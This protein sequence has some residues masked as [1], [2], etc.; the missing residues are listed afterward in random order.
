MATPPLILERVET[1]RRNLESYVSPDYKEAQLRREFL[2]P[3]F[4]ALGW[5]MQNKQGYA[6]AYK[7]VVH[8]DTLRISDLGTK[9]PD[10]SFRIGG[11]RKFFVEAKKPAVSIKD[12]PEPAQQLRRYS[13]SAKLPL[14]ILTDFQ[15]FAIYD[16]RIK[17]LKNDPP[18]KGRIFYCKFGEYPQ[19]WDEIAAIFSRDA[20]LK[21]SF[22]R[23]AVSVRGKRGTA[24]VDEDFLETLNGWRLRLAK[25]L[26]L[27]NGR[28]SQR[29]LNFA[30]QRILD[31][32][33]FLRI[34]E[35]RGI[36]NYGQLLA[37]T[38]SVQVEEAPD[39]ETEETPPPVDDLAVAEPTPVY[40]PRRMT[41]YPRLCE[42]FERADFR[43][44]SGLFHFH[45]EKGRDEAPDLLTLG[46]HIDDLVL[47]DII[48]GLYYPESPYVFSVIASEILGHVYEQFLGKVIRLTEG[49]RAV[50]E[51]KPEVR[52]AGGVYYTPTYIVDYI[53]RQAVG[54]LVADKTPKQ[55]EK[56]RILDPACEIASISWTHDLRVKNEL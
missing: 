25:N 40:H 56:L 16:T 38:G 20:V 19:K 13:W 52:K 39:E 31:R 33:I 43:Y 21:G 41:V 37:L 26:A 12:D 53:V 29:E 44:N 2:D 32:I 22:D 28:L 47:R 45:S 24:S 11:T 27:R 7:D 48:A 51:D 17:P 6:E 9:A 23:Y 4:E 55:V 10:Y 8:E 15:E 54:P 1:F 50:V 14:G 5:D 34:A 18:H 49:H 35:D 42:I 46:L 30:V 3:L 36:E